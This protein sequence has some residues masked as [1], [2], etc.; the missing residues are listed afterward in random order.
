MNDQ[1]S[2]IGLH[3]DDDRTLNAKYALT[4][5]KDATFVPNDVNTEIRI[6]RLIF[7]TAATFSVYIAIVSVSSNF[8]KIFFHIFLFHHFFF[9]HTDFNQSV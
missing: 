4:S 5:C 6:D 7:F 2:L 8:F 3:I 9:N 1:S